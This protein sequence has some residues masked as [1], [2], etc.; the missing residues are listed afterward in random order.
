VRNKYNSEADSF[1]RENQL[2][3]SALPNLPSEISLALEEKQQY[4][5]EILLSAP[6]GSNFTLEDITPDCLNTTDP[7]LLLPEE[8]R[9]IE[10]IRDEIYEQQAIL[11]ELITSAARE[12]LTTRQYSIFEQCLSLGLS[13][14]EAAKILKIKK[15]EIHQ[16]LFGH[17]NGTVGIL[18]KIRQ[19]LSTEPYSSQVAAS[20]QSIKSLQN[21]LL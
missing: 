15:Q 16:A 21:R 20:L 13:Q 12:T 10:E 5:K 19:T 2:Y 7:W 8:K 3:R 11:V 18:N 4:L 17:T 14:S 1:R 9:E 6:S